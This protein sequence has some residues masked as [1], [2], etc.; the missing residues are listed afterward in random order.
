VVPSIVTIVERVVA[1][2][3][4]A[5]NFRCRK[6]PALVAKSLSAIESTTGSLMFG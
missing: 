1:S 5:E 3:K 2:G 6:S 4:D